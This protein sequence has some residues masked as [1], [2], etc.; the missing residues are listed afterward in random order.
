M[1]KD[2]YSRTRR[3][4]KHVE[5]GIDWHRCNV[6][7]EDRPLAS[8]V[9]HADGVIIVSSTNVARIIVWRHEEYRIG[10][11]ICKRIINGCYVGGYVCCRRLVNKDPRIWIGYQHIESGMSWYCRH[12]LIKDGPLI[13]CNVIPHTS[14]VIIIRSARTAGI[15]VRRSEDDRIGMSVR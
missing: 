10:V 3:G 4:D 14:V 5:R 2:T 7:V 12:V 8:I 15:P 13:G 1:K 11:A 9:K 6:L